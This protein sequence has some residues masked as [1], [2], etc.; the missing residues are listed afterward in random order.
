M[1][2]A[3]FPCY[4]PLI[5]S[6]TDEWF[7]FIFLI[8]GSEIYGKIGVALC[9]FGLLK[10][11]LCICWVWPCHVQQSIKMEGTVFAPALEGIKNVKSEQGEI[12]SQP[13]LEVC[14]QI[15]PVIGTCSRSFTLLFCCKTRI[16]KVK[17]VYSTFW[18][19]LFC[20][21]NT[22]WSFWIIKCMLEIL[23]LP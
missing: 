5:I 8:S 6:Y 12:L 14:K 21:R 1:S 17:L 3:Y 20:E 19:V 16:V 10:F 15:L 11:Y 4:L 7:V 18:C 23:Y 2:F 13:F 22:E 9:R